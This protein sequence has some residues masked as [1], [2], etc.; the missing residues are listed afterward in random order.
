MSESGVDNF[1][2]TSSNGTDPHP[3]HG[4]ET[5]SGREANADLSPPVSCMGCS[6]GLI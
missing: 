1:S 2:R 6:D 4:L 5:I 3:N